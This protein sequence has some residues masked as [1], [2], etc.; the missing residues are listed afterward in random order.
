[1]ASERYVK[2]LVE[3]GNDALKNKMWEEGLKIFKELVEIYPKNASALTNYS[4]CLM[5]SSQYT[6]AKEILD[7]VEKLT[8]LSVTVN[9]TRGICLY[10]ERNLEKALESFKKCLRIDKE[11][12]ESWFMCARILREQENYTQS[13]GIFKNII[14]KNPRVDFLIELS[15]TFIGNNDFDQAENILKKILEVES[16]NKPAKEILEKLH[17]ALSEKRN[18]AT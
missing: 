15:L 11:H 12:E 4:L 9:H 10:L 7:K 3:K 6:K 13:I 17:K 16:G 2:S 18:L 14:K 8:P 5:N 1:M